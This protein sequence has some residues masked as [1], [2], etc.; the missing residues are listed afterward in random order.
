MVTNEK[1]FSFS[2]GVVGIVNIPSMFLYD[3]PI[4]QTYCLHD[5]TKLFFSFFAYLSN[6]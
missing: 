2:C 6:Y 3:K 5:S 1:G 4:A